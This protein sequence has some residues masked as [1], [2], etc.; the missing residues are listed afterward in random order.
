MAIITL[1]VSR[2]YLFRPAHGDTSWGGGESSTDCSF[3]SNSRGEV[4]SRESHQ[5]HCMRCLTLPAHRTLPL[6]RVLLDP[7]H[8]AVLSVV[9]FVSPDQDRAAHTM[10]KLW[11]HLPDTA[12][13]GK[14]RAER[15]D[16]GSLRRLQVSP[17]YRQVGHVPS[18]WFWQMP[19]TSSSGRS[20]RQVAT[21]AHFLI[22]TFISGG[23]SSKRDSREAAGYPRL[24]VK[25]L[26]TNM[27]STVVMTRP[28]RG[29]HMST[30]RGGR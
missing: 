24:L 18:N 28:A 5:A 12:K 2:A 27:Q 10:W 29:S 8:Y 6:G 15:W 23:L 20:Q 21:A 7:L 19:H 1:P 16:K 11:P 14:H 4:I 3:H 13:R 17:G 25:S 30:A 22:L 9:R 26:S